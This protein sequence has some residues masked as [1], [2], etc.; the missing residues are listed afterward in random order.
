MRHAQAIHKTSTSHS[1]PFQTLS[2]IISVF[3][4]NDSNIQL[5]H[6]VKRE[7]K[8]EKEGGKEGEGKREKGGDDTFRSC[9]VWLYR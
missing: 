7:Q 2:I 1:I 6:A 4:F 9:T 3:H 5:S 8:K